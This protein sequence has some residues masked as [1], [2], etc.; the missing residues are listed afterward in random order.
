MSLSFPH[1][2]RWLV[3]IAAASLLLT[4]GAALPAEKTGMSSE[5]IFVLEIILLL[6][7]GRGLGELLE[8]IGQP[9]VMGQLIGG[10]LLGPSLLGWLWP[11]AERLV[12]SGDASQKSMIN[13]IAQLGVLMLLLLTGMETDLRLVRRVGRACFSISAAGVAI[14][15]VLGFAAAQAM[16]ASLLAEGSER[17][18]AGLFLGTALSISSVKI[19]AMVVREMN[20]MRRDLGQIIVSSAIFEDTIGWVIIAITIGIATKG[21]IDLGSLAFTLA[22]VAAFMAFSFTIGRRIVF[23]AIRWT[24]DSFSSEYAVVTVILA[25]MGVMALITDLIGVH[26]VLGAFVAGILVGESPILSRH[27]EGQLRGVI[28]ALFMP[29]F[30]G[31]AGLSADLT[32]LLDRQLALLTVAL[33]A[34]ASLGKFAGAFIGAE[35]AGMSRREGIAVGCG[36]NARGSTEVIVASIGLSIGVLSHNLFT[37]IVTM[38]VITTLAMPPTLRW[39][40]GRLTLGEAEKK[41]LE[42]E[43]VDQRGFVAN[44]ER[45]LVV[46]DEGVVGR[47]AAYMAGVIGAGKPMTVL[48]AGGENEAEPGVELEEIEKG[49]EHNR[50]A[51]KEA[52]ERPAARAPVTRRHGRHVSAETVAREARK[53]Y[54][55][56]I[57]GL[58]RA[59]AAKGSFTRRLDE[60]AGAF[61]GPLCLVLKPAAAGRQMPRL[62]AGAGRILV[63]VNGTSVA[64]RGAELAL[65]IA[66]VTGAPVKM[67]YVARVGRDEPRDTVSHR[68]REA[69][70]KDIVALA[71]RYG[72]EVETAIRSRAAAADAIARQAGR[73]VAMIV[74]GVARR[75][76]EELLFGE[77][78]SSVLQHCRCPVVLI[79]DERLPRDDAAR[80]ALRSGTG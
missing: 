50:E 2:W 43:E 76:G 52:D 20:F 74:M 9:A 26:T 78:T 23:D 5:G 55:M 69:V 12:F 14:P 28:T 39:A 72:V 79:S 75:P 56:L 45:L 17:V 36:M 59:L 57:V 4:P 27:I 41:R 34:I 80:E 8:R 44:L 21:R 7:V 13:A 29:V 10:I 48:H 1:K 64:R 53:G 67:L 18:V 60:I 61:D 51:A 65:A 42:R 46:A 73:G 49:A 35:L 58:G 16:P 40:L 63:P 77:T 54:G 70:L 19:V 11:E 33:V 6:V 38:A 66:A 3:V 24:N 71:D 22:G 37:M 32:V 31:V 25:I 68:R 62:G 30:F 47:F 15:F